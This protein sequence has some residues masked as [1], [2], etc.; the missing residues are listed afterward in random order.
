MALYAIGDVQGCD[1][2]L[3]ELLD[4]LRFSPDKD[5]LW[6][7]GDLVNRGPASL[8]VLRRVRSLGDAASVVL[9]NHDLHLLALAHGFGR[10]K[11]D[12]TLSEVLRAPDRD[13]LIEWLAHRPLCVEDHALNRCLLH[14]G[15]PPQWDM[16]TARAA[17][18]ASSR[19]R[20]AT[21]PPSFSDRCTATIRIFGTR[22]SAGRSVCG[23]P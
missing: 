15:L 23:T 21:L 6:F 2:E 4:A 16:P 3:G 7:A 5:R 1:A 13:R 11:R 19:R 8:E 20:C 10:L 18:R 22:L 12:D 17:A 14:A 9:G